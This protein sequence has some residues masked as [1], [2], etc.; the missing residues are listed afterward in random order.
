MRFEHVERIKRGYRAGPSPEITMIPQ[1][2]HFFGSFDWTSHSGPW[3]YMQE[4]PLVFYGPGWVRPSGDTEIGREVTV[5]D[6]APTLAELM[7]TPFPDDRPGRVIEEVLVPAERRRTAPAAIVVVVWD[8]AGINAL[9]RWPDAWP[10]LEGLIEEGANAKGAIVGSSP[11][12]TPPVHATIG[13][14]TFPDTHGIV[15]IP[16]RVDGEIADSYADNTASNLRVRALAEIHDEHHDNAARIAMFGER[17][18]L[19]GMIGQG[20]YRETG[21]RDVAVLV[22]GGKLITNPDWYT[23]PGYL[24]ELP[25]IDQDVERVDAIDGELDGAWMGHP[26]DNPGNVTY[27]PVWPYYQNRIS[28]SILQGEDFGE[29]SITDLFFTNYKAIDHVG[30]R[31]NMVNPEMEV[32]IEASDDALGELVEILDETVGERRWVL[33]LTAD[34]GQ[35]PD[36]RTFDAWPVDLNEVGADVARHFEL[37]TDELIE[38]SRP[39]GMWLDPDVMESNGITEDA[40]ARFLLDYTIEDN[41]REN[42]EVPD[43]YSEMMQDQVFEAVFPSRDI[44]SIWNCARHR[45]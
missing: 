21:D 1:Y 22:R 26:L 34:H 32:T 6:L 39:L 43:G 5:A 38:D 44:P 42:R 28:H 30:H 36:P 13:T 3:R 40:I 9:T 2:P 17:A 14:G 24:D 29:D 10:F 37:D 16:Q 35:A 20:A 33:A 18:W 27:S 15:D 8:G 12:L 7:G 11:S 4:V 19:L 45:T 23:L 31:Y 41:V 25:S